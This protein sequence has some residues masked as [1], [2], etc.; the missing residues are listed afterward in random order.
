MSPKKMEMGRA[1]RALRTM[2]RMRL[3]TQRPYGGVRVRVC[4]CV[5]GVCACACVCVRERERKVDVNC[6]LDFF[7]SDQGLETVQR[8]IY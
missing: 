4:V 6:I 8:D 2:P 3:V 5:C 1:G 7:F